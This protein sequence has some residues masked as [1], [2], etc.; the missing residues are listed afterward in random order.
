MTGTQLGL[1]QSQR[2][3]RKSSLASA[4]SLVGNTQTTSL[5]SERRRESPSEGLQ[6]TGVKPPQGLVATGGFSACWR[7]VPA[8]QA[9]PFPWPQP[10]NSRGF[11]SE[12]GLTFQN[13]TT[14]S[15]TSFRPPDPDRW[16]RRWATKVP[17]RHP[18]LVLFVPCRFL[19]PSCPPIAA[20]WSDPCSAQAQAQATAE[21]SAPPSPCPSADSIPSQSLQVQPETQVQACFTA[22]LRISLDTD[23][24]RPHPAAPAVCAPTAVTPYLDT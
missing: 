17:T 6:G 20:R 1:Y 8:F 10:V 15:S 23:F 16:A 13:T 2:F 4:G 7:G 3:W 22:G 18:V 24:N 21:A 12:L 19:T 9:Q 5:P 14:T 11:T